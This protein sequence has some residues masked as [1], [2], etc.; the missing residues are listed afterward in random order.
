LASPSSLALGGGFFEGRDLSRELDT[1]LKNLSPVLKSFSFGGFEINV[2]TSDFIT[3]YLSAYWHNLTSLELHQVRFSSPYGT[4][5][6][7]SDYFWQNYARP[8]FRLRKVTIRML[9]TSNTNEWSD[10]AEEESWL[11]WI[12]ASSQGSLRSL[13]ID[14]L[15]NALPEDAMPLLQTMSRNLQD[16]SI[17]DYLVPEM[18]GDL[19]TAHAR[20]LLSLTLGTKRTELYQHL[21][22]RMMPVLASQEVWNNREQLRYLEIQHQELFDVLAVRKALEEGK[23][24]QLQVIVLVHVSR[25]HPEVQQL[26]K[27]CQKKDV[28]LIVKR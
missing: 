5:R 20:Q 13:S 12:L 25:V 10:S 6:T 9:G 19:L 8:K 22:V 7:A 2:T 17:T 3:Y 15:C 18:A 24:P 16:I 21:D 27:Y 28:I 11:H 1:A 14:G 23:L 26:V 4:T